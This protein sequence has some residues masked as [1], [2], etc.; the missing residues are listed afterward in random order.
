MKTLSVIAGAL[1][2]AGFIPYVLAILG[3]NI[4]L[5]KI[6]P[7]KPAKVS[8]I[9]WGSLDF[10]TF[11]A[12]YAANTVNGQI[13]GAVIGV[14]V[15]IIF[16][17][18]YGTP[19][20]TKLDKRCLGGAILGVVLWQMFDSPELGIITSCIVAFIGSFPTFESAWKDPSHEDKLA[21]TVFWI[22]CVCAVIAIPRWTWADAAQPV[23]FFIIESV[24]MYILYIHARRK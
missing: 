21:W 4:W 20:W 11:A 3:R 2:I 5:Q 17:I 24:M 7:I 9:I 12:M 22:S 14:V 15:V 23:S 19:G 13:T 8:W 10:I 18:K 16:A 1:F 6:R